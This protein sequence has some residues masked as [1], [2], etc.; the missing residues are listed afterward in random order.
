MVFHDVTLPSTLRIFAAFCSQDGYNDGSFRSLFAKHIR[1]YI[2][3]PFHM[4][5]LQSPWCRTTNCKVIIACH[6][7]F[8]FQDCWHGWY[9]TRPSFGIALWHMYILDDN[10]F[11]CYC[12]KWRNEGNSFFLF[13]HRVY[14]NKSLSFLIEQ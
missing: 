4:V 14:L 9:R 6:N 11:E 12:N 8:N 1:N 7:L 10:I 5:R 3:Y 13:C 2:L